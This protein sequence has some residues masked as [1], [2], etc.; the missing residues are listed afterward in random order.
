MWYEFYCAGNL[1]VREVH[2]DNGDTK[3]FHHPLQVKDYNAVIA[4]IDDRITAKI[5]VIKT[6]K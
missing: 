3:I 1:L 6:E 5:R 4:Y 2:T